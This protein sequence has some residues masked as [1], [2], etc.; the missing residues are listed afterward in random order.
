[1]RE[2]GVYCEIDLN[3]GGDDAY[4]LSPPLIYRGMVYMNGSNSL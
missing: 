2:R 4:A 3:R 1:M